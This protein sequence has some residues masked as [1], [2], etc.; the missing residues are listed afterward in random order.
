MKEEIEYL[1][2]INK[3]NVFFNSMDFGADVKSP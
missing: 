3:I 2:H 1:S